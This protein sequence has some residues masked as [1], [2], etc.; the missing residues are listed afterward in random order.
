MLVKNRE[1]S[2]EVLKRFQRG[3]IK[4]V[5]SP[6]P[7]AS[8]CLLITGQPP[9]EVTQILKTLPH[10]KNLSEVVVTN[11]NGNLSLENVFQG[12]YPSIT[13]LVFVNCGLKR[14]PDT[15]A[16]HFP[17][18]RILSLAKNR[19]KAIP[20]CVGD[21]VN[22]QSL[23][24]SHNNL[25]T[26]PETLGQLS[27]LKKIYCAHNKLTTLPDALANLSDSLKV[28]DIRHNAIRSLP[29]AVTSLLRQLMVFQCSNNPLTKQVGNR[30]KDVV[31]YLEELQEGI[32]LNKEIKLVVVGDKT[33]GK[34]TLVQALKSASGTSKSDVDKTD[35]IEITT[36]KTN[37]IDFRIFDTGGDVDFLETHLLFTSPDCL[38]LN[39]FNL[40]TT[41]IEG[42][43]GSQLGRLQRWLNSIY[44]QAPTSR[45]LIV[46]THADD[47]KLGEE[48]KEHVRERLKKILETAH[49]AHRRKFREEAVEDCI[50]CQDDLHLGTGSKRP[51][52]SKEK[53]SKRDSKVLGANKEKESVASQPTVDSDEHLH[54]ETSSIIANM[55]HIVGY[56]EVS[57]V[58]KYPYNL[59]GK[60]SSVQKLRK[61]LG[62]QAEKV[63]EDLPKTPEKWMD[64]RKNLSSH[65]TQ[66][67]ENPVLSKKE[68]QEK[69]A[70]YGVTK[71][72]KFALMLRFFNNVGHLVHHERVPD[73]V[74]LDPQWFADRLSSLLSFKQDWLVDGILTHE[75][76]ERAW[77]S[78]DDKTR[79]DILHLF[80]HFK[81]CF[82]VDDKRELF[83]CRLPVGQPNPSFWPPMPDKA[84]RQVSYMCWFSFVSN[85]LFP[86]I[87][88]EVNRNKD[89]VDPPKPRYFCN[90]I[91]Y[92]T[93]EEPRGCRNCAATPSGHHGKHRVHIEL[94]HH[95]DAVMVTVRGPR[96]CCIASRLL[97]TI[98]SIAGENV[99][100]K[101]SLICPQCVVGQV[102]K[103]KFLKITQRHQVSCDSGHR[104]G[105]VSDLLQG[106]IKFDL[107]P[108]VELKSHPLGDIHCPRLFVMLP[109][110][111]EALSYLEYIQ[112]TILKDG[113]AVHFLC[114]QKGEWH[115]LSKPG[116]PLRRVKWFVKA[117]GGRA[118]KM[119][120]K[121]VK[122]EVSATAVD[123]V[124]YPLCRKEA[125]SGL[126]RLLNAYRRSFPHMESDAEVVILEEPTPL[127][128]LTRKQLK[129]L[130]SISDD[131]DQPEF[132]NLYPT[133]VNGKVLWL[134]QKHYKV[135]LEEEE[136]SE[137][138]KH[139]LPEPGE[140]TSGEGATP[141]NEV[142]TTYQPVPAD[143]RAS[144][145]SIF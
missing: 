83:P 67:K 36:L 95:E 117:Y 73:T 115:F 90:R 88:V 116:F 17:N 22:L 125:H 21:L 134:C 46:G 60:N 133:H 58:T 27:Q 100:I 18:V 82:P 72:E 126:E 65:S 78:M 55:P 68:V 70:Q 74:V 53:K 87:I 47:P 96:P 6:A 142:N 25:D 12:E 71:E 123:S 129:K 29:T 35:G 54:D 85:V 99:T 8:H 43:T 106:K 48:V 112:Y 63:L 94:I 79:A 56:H 5:S 122:K 50:L 143:P 140:K 76:L 98:K 10:D 49:Q 81:I 2:A 32:A 13:K 38:Y 119:L 15:F 23:Q 7:E 37:D 69:A 20:D 24:I 1:V 26:C 61:S 75:D 39:V 14:I 64:V 102:D 86:E 31:S 66:N 80:R 34:T 41:D 89:V 101:L 135:T 57:S 103:P 121:I 120:E 97:D 128:K 52:E 107:Q 62:R 141:T 111:K 139:V 113:F 92:E 138:R 3:V 136:P 30:K 33:V 45:N 4:E 42:N 124:C 28:V 130:L 144:S 105:L 131:A 9:K 132:P 110:N 91:L 51:N 118:F 77:E 84:E 40:A 59:F 104:V 93:S 16:K 127:E 109:V 114:E 19:L 137:T 108:P 44:T 145:V 11:V